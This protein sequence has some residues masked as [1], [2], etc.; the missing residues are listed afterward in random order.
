MTNTQLAQM[1]LSAII[2]CNEQI[3]LFELNSVLIGKKTKGIKEKGFDQIKTFGGGS[4]YS[5]QQWHYIFIQMIQ[6]ELFA[7]DY[8]NTYHLKVTKKGHQVLKGELEITELKIGYPAASAFTKNGIA[9]H[10]DDDIK[11]SINWKKL[12]NYFNWIIYWNYTSEK[13]LDVNKFIP[14]RINE[15]EKVKGRFLELVQQ[16]YNLT[17][18]G[19]E[20]IIPLKVD[21]DM[22]GNVVQPLSL[23]FDECLE[24]LRQFIETTNRY[25]QMNAVSEEV[26]L[27]KWYREVEHGIQQ[28]TPEQKVLFDKFKEQ[29]PISNYRS[30]KINAQ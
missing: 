5:S 13:R 14:Y 2:R 4:A 17:I 9:V 28:V 11:D 29:Y 8:E 21:Y 16:L 19:E 1:A 10:L 26:A 20:I 7:I 22:F 24:K 30:C 23:P 25:P 15:R 3:T 27:R 18:D 12:L 6:Q